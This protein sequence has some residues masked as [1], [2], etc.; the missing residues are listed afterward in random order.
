MVGVPLVAAM[1]VFATTLFVG[2]YVAVMLLIIFI[3]YRA[4]NM[5]FTVT[6]DTLFIRG[7]FN[8]NV[9]PLKTITSVQKTPTPFG[10]RLFGASFLGGLYHLP[11]IGRT[12][13][14]MGNF[15]DGV[16][17]TT[18]QKK[19]FF[20]TPQQPLAFINIVKKNMR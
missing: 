12:W 16:L 8:T 9:V 7:I 15:E 10:F 19:H 5:T 17:I 3:L 11:G 13:V 4:S 20:I 1:N 14:A 2:V 18:K 6:R